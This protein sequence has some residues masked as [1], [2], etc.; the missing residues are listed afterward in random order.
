MRT[1]LFW[2]PWQGKTAAGSTAGH[3][4]THNAG[5]NSCV[6][7]TLC[8]HACVIAEGR[9]GFC[10][11]RVNRGGMLY[12]L[13]DDNVA[14][15]GLDPVEK[16]PLFHFLPGTQ[17]LSLGTYG[18]NFACTFCQNA[19]ISRSPADTG[20]F[21]KGDPVTARRIV[22]YAKE[23]HIPSISCTY[24][25]PTVFYELVHDIA[26]EASKAGRRIILVSN[27]AMS[28]A[29]LASLKGL[30]HAANIDLKAFHKDFYSRI[31]SGSL[32]AVLDNLVRMKAMGIWLE[33][34]T[35][36]IPGLND[37][38]QELSSIAGFIR[39]NLGPE[40]PWHVSAFF[41]CYK[42]QDRGPTPPS[43]IHRAC[44]LGRAQ[45]LHYVYG[46]NVSRPEDEA[47]FCPSCHTP[48]ISRQGFRVL[49]AC[50]G[51]CPSCGTPIAG[52]WA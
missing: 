21:Y 8:F 33:V 10:G 31:C 12:T 1:A 42:M 45:G 26:L 35:L 46:G 5:N 50:T 11:V 47:T 40:T 20:R 22:D 37:S 44:E 23:R 4:V 2:E 17:T 6:R 25:E 24:N 34:T 39:D 52:V 7:C 49:S 27:G 28:A 16:K 32:T 36:V 30:V 9:A 15:M 19:R 41:P 43:L 51:V 13:V 18:C 29:A 38:E 48:C 3:T 14:S